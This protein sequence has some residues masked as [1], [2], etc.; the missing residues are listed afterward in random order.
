MFGASVSELYL[1]IK[2]LIN[3]KIHSVYIVDS[4][5]LSYLLLFVFQFAVCCKAIIIIII[6]GT[7]S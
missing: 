6:I 2:S 4:F 5:A 1:L 7:V 3:K